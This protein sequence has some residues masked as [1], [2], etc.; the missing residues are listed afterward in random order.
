[1]LDSLSYFE[2]GRQYPPRMEF[3]RF[4]RIE[5][6]RHLYNGD[7]N[8]IYYDDEL[9]KGTEEDRANARYALKTNLFRQGS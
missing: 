4:E 5:T 7:I 3:Q 9:G 6:N 1:M 8:R 2:Q